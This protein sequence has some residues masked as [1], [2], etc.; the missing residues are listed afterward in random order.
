MIRLLDITAIIVVAAGVSAMSIRLV[1]NAISDVNSSQP[2]RLSSVAFDELASE[3]YRIG[4]SRAAVTIV[5]FSSYGCG[6]SHTLHE[7]LLDLLTRHSDVALV[8]RH[9]VDPSSSV[10]QLAVGAGCAT[11]QRAFAAYHS[12][13][14]RNS[15]VA[16]YWNGAA[17][18]A[19]SARIPDLAAFGDCVSRGSSLAAAAVDWEAAQRLGVSSTPTMFVNGIRIV[20]TPPASFLDDMIGAARPPETGL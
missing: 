6:W 8:V 12:E 4:P 20:G 18:V 13:A 17:I 19:D 10:V 11:E 2:V 14:F 3:G 5:V 16:E 7:R 1:G 9:L 15:R